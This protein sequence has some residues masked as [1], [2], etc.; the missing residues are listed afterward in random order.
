MLRAIHAL[1]RDTPLAEP[2]LVQAVILDRYDCINKILMRAGFEAQRELVYR[3]L[4]RLDEIV[5]WGEKA[6]PTV[7]FNT[8][9]RT[10]YFKEDIF[11]DIVDVSTDKD[12]EAGDLYVPPPPQPMPAPRAGGKGKGKGKSSKG[13][14]NLGHLSNKGRG[15]TRR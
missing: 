9:R 3:L 13:G 7:Q 11:R 8:Y 14:K 4:G 10:P 1:Y 15:P 12:D 5:P 6:H 2:E